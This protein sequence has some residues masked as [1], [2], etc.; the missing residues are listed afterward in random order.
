[1]KCCFHSFTGNISSSESILNYMPGRS[2]AD[3]AH[4]DF[5]PIF[6]DKMH[7]G[8]VA[9]ATAECGGASVS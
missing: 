2:A 4:A 1:M 9:N 7:S 3:Y 6:I 8:L 5:E